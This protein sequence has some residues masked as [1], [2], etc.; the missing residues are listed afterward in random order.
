MILGSFNKI[1]KFDHF[2]MK[3]KKFGFFDKIKNKF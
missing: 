1:V 2:N 3:I